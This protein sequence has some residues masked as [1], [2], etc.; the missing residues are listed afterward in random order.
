MHFLKK[1][2]DETRKA[3]DEGDYDLNLR[4]YH[5]RK[6][7]SESIINS[8]NIAII[9]EIK[10]ASPSLGKI[11]EYE[12][13]TK[14]ARE[15]IEGGAVGLSILTSRAFN[16]SLNYLL[17]VRV[18]VDHPLL[19]KDIMIDKRQI[20]AASRA[21]ADCIL[22]IYKI[23]DK[24]YVTDLDG[25]IEHAH[26]NDLEVLLEV[27]DQAEFD[28]ALKSDADIIGI[29]NRDLTTM[30]IDINTTEQLLKN[31][32]SWQNKII[33][34]ESGINTPEEIKRL[35]KIGVKGFLIGTSI[36]KSNNIKEKLYELVR[37]VE[38]KI[39]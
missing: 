39:S 38:Y 8:N 6:R 11:R 29:N 26:D 4:V 15:M 36:M 25:F 21:G 1:L 3:I 5:N 2:V 24:G 32:N 27:H 28:A 7:L 13:P 17:N 20:D 14:I 22:L 34:S 16:G 33:I 12:D 9:S 23:F 35:Y 31:N 37:A 18:A 19:M 10:F 30:K